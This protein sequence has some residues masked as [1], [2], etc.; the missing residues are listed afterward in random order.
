MFL[1]Q[2]AYPDHNLYRDG[3]PGQMHHDWKIPPREEMYVN[4]HTRRADWLIGDVVLRNCYRLG[5]VAC[6]AEVVSAVSV[7]QVE[8]HQF[9]CVSCSVSNGSNPLE[10]FRVRVGTG[11]EP[12]QWVLPHNNLD[13]CNWAGFTTKNPAFQPHEHCLPLRIW[14]LIEWWYDQYV[15]CAVLAA[16]L[17]PT[18]GFAIQPILVEL[19]SKPREYRAKFRVIPQWFNWYWSDGKSEYGR[20]NSG[21]NCTIN[22]LIMSR[23]NQNSDC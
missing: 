21:Q 18:F 3:Y 9:L 15:D 8:K 4:T 23:Y 19:L 10:P 13:R 5:Q 22:V 14:V 7:G 16:P 6:Q 20:L 17:P 1:H 11:T 12:L 2:W